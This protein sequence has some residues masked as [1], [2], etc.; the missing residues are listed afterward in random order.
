MIMADRKE[1]QKVYGNITCPRE[2]CVN[3]TIIAQTQIHIGYLAS[4]KDTLNIKTD[5]QT[6]NHTL[7]VTEW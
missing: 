6:P 2:Y 7:Q 4:Q 3:K 5:F 1:M